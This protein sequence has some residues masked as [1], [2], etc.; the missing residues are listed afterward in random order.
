MFIVLKI[1]CKVNQFKPSKTNRTLSR[2]LSFALFK[3]ILFGSELVWSPIIFIIK[4]SKLTV[5]SK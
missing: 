2:I 4:F 3:S 5:P 1:T